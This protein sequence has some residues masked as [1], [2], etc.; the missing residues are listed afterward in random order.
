MGFAMQHIASTRQ[1]RGRHK[2]P[3]PLEALDEQ[4]RR[5]YWT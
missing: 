3:P 4:L 5:G 1:S 2:A